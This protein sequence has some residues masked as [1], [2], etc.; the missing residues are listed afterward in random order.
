MVYDLFW[1]TADVLEEYSLS[2][3]E[4]NIDFGVMAYDEP[5]GNAYVEGLEKLPLKELKLAYSDH[6]PIWMRFNVKANHSDQ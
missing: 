2:K 5:G 6:R 1:L 4:W 3:N